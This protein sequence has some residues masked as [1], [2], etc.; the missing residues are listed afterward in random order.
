[1]LLIDGWIEYPYS[2]TNFAAWQAEIQ[3][4][5]PSIEV[6][7]A[8]GEW[9]PLHE[10]FGFPA[11]MPRAMSVP[12]AGL[13]EGTRELRVRTNLEVYWDQIRVVYSEACPE[14]QVVELPFTLAKLARVGFAARSTFPQ[15]RPY[16]DYTKR[17]GTWDTRHQEGD[18]TRFGDVGE[19][20]AERDNALAI[21]GPGEEVHFEFSAP[22][23]LS[24][25]T[26]RR[27]YLLSVAGWC[28]DMDL[29]T[30]EGET[31]EP[32]P[33]DENQTTGSNRHRELNRRYN[34]RYRAGK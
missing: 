1:V 33:F 10:Q 13:P 22:E 28:K 27:W 9:T 24:P 7:S 21:F 18:Y 20:V 23:A 31:L 5:A 17:S 29:Y 2:Q 16:Y 11:G 6:R 30:N 14:A 3:Q 34:T 4:V 8:D 12:L 32:L 26:A 25:A 19:L 15:R